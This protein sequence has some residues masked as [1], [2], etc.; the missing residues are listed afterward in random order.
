MEALCVNLSNP[1]CNV[2]QLDLM[3]CYYGTIPLT[4]WETPCIC[5]STVVSAGYLYFGSHVLC[6]GCYD[7]FRGGKLDGFLEVLRNEAKLNIRDVVGLQNFSAPKFSV[8][9]TPIDFPGY[10]GTATLS[11]WL[12]RMHI[13]RLSFNRASFGGSFGLVQLGKGL[14]IPSEVTSLSFTSCNLGGRTGFQAFIE[15]LCDSQSSLIHLSLQLHNNQLDLKSL[16]RL[17]KLSPRL[18]TL[19][20][21]DHLTVGIPAQKELRRIMMV[22]SSR[23]M[24]LATLLIASVSRPRRQNEGDGKVLGSLSLDI[25]RLV[26]ESLPRST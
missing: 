1:K 7:A 17:A 23:W 13:L 26:L 15:S 25:I 2:V 21:R 22:Q 19:N 20:I 16:I 11:G 4:L 24:K 6:D 12:K 10:D 14:R 5:G 18:R 9:S 8:D 3:E